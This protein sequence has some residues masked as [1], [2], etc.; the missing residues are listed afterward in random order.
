V[1]S[2]TKREVTRGK[3]GEQNG[4]ERREKTEKYN[5]LMR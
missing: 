3:I 5:T 4:K 2:Q 1:P